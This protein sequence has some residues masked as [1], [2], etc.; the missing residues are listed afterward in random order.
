MCYIVLKKDN[1]EF[2][3]WTSNNFNCYVV[4][5]IFSEIESKFLVININLG[6]KQF[7]NL[8][9]KCNHIIT[10]PPFQIRQIQ[11]LQALHPRPK[12]A[13]PF[14]YL[15]N[16][17]SQKSTPS[18]SLSKIS[19]KLARTDYFLFYLCISKRSAAFNF[20]TP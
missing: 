18:F 1:E 6:P 2:T 3:P 10:P 19:I 9:N 15:T 16:N 20:K 17:C 7:S 14:Q 4:N 8:T 12:A 13:L 5:C 11:K